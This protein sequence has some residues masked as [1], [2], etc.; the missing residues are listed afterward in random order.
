MDAFWEGFEKQAVSYNK[1][2][3]AI[4]KRYRDLASGAYKA[5]E[6]F[7]EESHMGVLGK[8]SPLDLAK[9]LGLGHENIPGAA[10]AFKNKKTN[11][12]IAGSYKPGRQYEEWTPELDVR[13]NIRYSISAVQ[14]KRPMNLSE[15]RREML[16]P[17]EDRYF[18]NVEKSNYQNRL[19][20][21]ADNN[22]GHLPDGHF[23]SLEE[24]FMKAHKK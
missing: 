12:A 2:R 4:Q 23:D 21:D 18:G 16:L 24:K 9:N 7:V 11:E 13:N 22:P 6:P 8:H 1:V 20:A 3:A 14:G 17:K 5:S 19:W 10:Q 15:K